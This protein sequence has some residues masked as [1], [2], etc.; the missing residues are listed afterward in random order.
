MVSLGGG[1]MSLWD[2]DVS[3]QGSQAR[4]WRGEGISLNMISPRERGVLVVTWSSCLATPGPQN[5]CLQEGSGPGLSHGL[6][7]DLTYSVSD[8]PPPS[9]S[10]QQPHPLS[11]PV[12]NPSMLPPA[13]R[14][15]LL[16][17]H[18]ASGQSPSNGG[19]FL[20]IRVTVDGSK[21]S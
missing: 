16:A 11:L 19:Y 20:D 17:S 13:H 4:R 5:T 18:P 2:L 6:C 21:M 1:E 12:G 9:T 3:S 14:P 10:T 15:T 8:P 7:V